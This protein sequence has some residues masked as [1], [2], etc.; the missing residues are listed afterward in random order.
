MFKKLTEFTYKRNFKEAVGFYFAYL[1]LIMILSGTIAGISSAL[2]NSTDY[3]EFGTR[4]GTVVGSISC[5]FL[6]FTILKGKNLL[7]NFF[8]LILALI[9]G[10]LPL[11]A[12]A[13]LG[14]I[15][16]A[17]FSTLKAKMKK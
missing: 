5:I 16:P 17:Y 12:G 15:I 4:V 9:S 14:L 1:L 6:A 3:F 13:L 10:I 8:Y 2:I 7:N 11:F